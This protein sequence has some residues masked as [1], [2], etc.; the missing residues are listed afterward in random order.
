MLRYD[1]LDIELEEYSLTVIA[2]MIFSDHIRVASDSTASSEEYDKHIEKLEVIEGHRLAFGMCGN[3]TVISRFTKW[4]KD[5]CAN[6][7]DLSWDVLEEQTWGSLVKI[8]GKQREMMALAGVE[9]KGDD[10]ADV[11]IAGYLKGKPKI[12]RIDHNGNIDDGEL[13]VAAIGSG[14]SV[15]S[16]GY[17]TLR[18]SGVSVDEKHFDICSVVAAQMGKNCGLPIQRAKIT[19]DGVEI[20]EP[21]IQFA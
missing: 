6:N 21:L 16:V 19:P 20:L 3:S 8:N 11:L 5:Y 15:F 7:A 9:A 12:I 14:E 17:V 2:A 18:R 13:E 1:E 4:F 10:L